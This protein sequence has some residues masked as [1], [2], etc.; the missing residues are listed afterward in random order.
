MRVVFLASGAFAIPSLEALVAAGHE[1]AAL[2]TQ[3]D[4]AS[5]RGLALVPPKVKP[6][7]ERH[8]IQVLQL[9]RV[10]TPEAQEAL[11]R[12]APELQVVVAFGQILP[13]AVIEIAPRG[14]D[15]R[16]RVAAAPAARRRP[17]PVGDRGAVHRDGRHHDADRRGPRYRAPAARPRAR[18]R[19]RRDRGRPRAA[20][21]GRS[22]ASCS[23][24][25]SRGSS[26]ARSRPSPRTR[27]G[28]RSRRSSARRTAGS[29]GRSPRAL[30][31]AG[32]AASIPG[33]VHDTQLRRPPAQ[34]LRVRAR[35][36]KP[37]GGAPGTSID[38]VGGGSVVA[39]GEGS[40]L[41]CSRRS[42]PRAA[43]RCRLPRGRRGSAP[44]PAPG[45]AE[46][47]RR[48][49]GRPRSRCCGASR[50]VAAR[51]TRSS[52][53]QARLPRRARPRA[54][55]ELVLG[56]RCAAAAGSTT[57][58]RASAIV[59]SRRW[60]RPSSR[61]CGSAPTS[62]CTC[63][64]RRTRRSRSRSISH[65]GGAARGRLRERG[66][67][68]A[69]ARRPARRAGSGSGSRRV[70]EHGRI[71]P[72]LA[73]G[74]LARATGRRRGARAHAGRAR[75]AAHVRAPEPARERRGRAPLGGRREPG[76]HAHPRG[77][78]GD[79][80]RAR[81]L[82][83]AGHRLRPGRGLAA[84]GAAGRRRGSLARRL[85]GPRRQG[86]ADGRR[87]RSR[88]AHRRRGGL[89][90][91][92]RGAAP[93]RRAL[94]GDADLAARGRCAA[95]A[96]PR[97]VRRCPAG[98]ALQRPRHARSQ[99]RPALAASARRSRPVTPSGSAPCS[100]A[101]HRSYGRAERSST[102]RARSSA[103]RPTTSS[104]RSW[105]ATA[106]LPRTSCPNGRGRSPW[107]G[108]SSSTRHAAPATASSQSSCG[109]GMLRRS[110]L[111]L[112][113][114]GRRPYGRR[115]PRACRRPGVGR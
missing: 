10:R 73:R 20:P 97:G 50:A 30:I 14:D 75:G 40:L 111:T 65:A 107:E 104:T 86:A 38:G 39:C 114:R 29:T 106:P 52:A 92:P 60:S 68:P 87:R 94:G 99:S 54:L 84:R 56:L 1:V 13:R 17:D 41:A 58:S 66:P 6:V 42:S 11:R 45:S 81:R 69:A 62:S 16:A 27:R 109:G 2:V 9:P 83:G 12:L 24:R 64:S 4:R 100:R 22:A 67:A 34:A 7:A 18:D 71:A 90:P 32:C 8:G 59:P 93:A 21:R 113:R 89:S 98:R 112:H 77:L 72:P 74:A 88:H 47:W 25:R 101:S 105:L 19:T 28:P 78:P 53:S 23:S 5:G 51:S 115:R 3:P 33:R 49:P 80:R 35:P 36:G 61:C 55:H 82:R 46:R 102:P 26:A 15:Q 70:D 57:S 37:A 85:R 79:R 48:R 44:A 108:A 31:A 110:A 63:A 103:R 95:A 43:R 91:P 76:A 96:F